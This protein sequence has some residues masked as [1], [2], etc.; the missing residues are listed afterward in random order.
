MHGLILTGFNSVSSVSAN[1][2]RTGGAHRIATYLR[3]RDWDIEVLDFVMGW[4]L[5]QLQEFT[6]SRITNKTVFIGFGSTFP[7]WSDTLE[8]YFNWVKSTYPNIKIIAGGQMSNNYR[9]EADWYVDGF[10]E[11]ALEALLKHIA[12]GEKVKYQL[13]INGRKVVKGNTDY[14]SFP[15]KNLRI[16]Y[17][18]RDFILADETLVTEF[19]RG[20][21]FNCSFCNF[22]ILGVK[23]DHSR[24]AEDLRLELQDTYDRFGVTK[25]VIADETVNDYTAKLQKFQTAIKQLTFKPR[26]F[27]FARADLL[28]SRKQDWDIMLD[29]GFV[30]HHYGVESTNLESLK[31]IGKGMHPDKLLPGLLEARNYFKKH[32]IY[33]GQVSLIAGLPYETKESLEKTLVWF[34]TNWKTENVM[35]FPMYI[36]KPTGH[37]NFS[38]LT[39]DWKKYNYRETAYDMYPSIRKVF[40]ELPTQYGMGESLLENTGM[41]WENDEWNIMDVMKI[42]ANFYQHRYIQNYGPVLWSLGEFELAFNK[43]FEYYNDKTMQDLIGADNFGEMKNFLKTSSYLIQEYITKKLNWNME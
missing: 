16:R 39:T 4:N 14:P 3:D 5:E 15:M 28:V 35:L 34:E 42:V 12:G 11:R 13:G 20:C 22:P 38:K 7:I 37:D 10:G 43:P 32:S 2:K 40:Q 9:I 21:I 41:S 23:E 27:G 6:R 25:Y 18:D 33:K 24:D 17:E 8:S 36:P 30:G 1:Y 19:G 26:F 31:A 29:M